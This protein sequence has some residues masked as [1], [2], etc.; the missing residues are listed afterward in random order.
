[1]A[2]TNDDPAPASPRSFESFEDI[3][4]ELERI[5]ELLRNTPALNHNAAE[6]LLEIARDIRSDLGRSGA[7]SVGSDAP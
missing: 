7:W 4:S 3:A 5:A 1:M 6:R 2:S